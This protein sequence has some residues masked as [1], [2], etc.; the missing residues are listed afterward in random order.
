MR[1]RLCAPSCVKASCSAIAIELRAPFDELL[2]GRGTFFDQRVDGRRS[3]RPSP[4]AMVSCSCSSTSSSSL[5]ATAMPPWAYSDEDSL[6][7]V[8]GD[9]QHLAGLRQLDGR[10]QPGYTSADDE[11]IRIHSQIKW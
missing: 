10:A 1:L 5:S 8:F 6:Q 4:A 3:Q 9:D 7:G 2:N 11:E